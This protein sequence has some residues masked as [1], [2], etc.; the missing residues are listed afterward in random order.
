[1]GVG[2]RGLRDDGIELIFGGIDAGLRD[3]PKKLAGIRD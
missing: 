2:V 1:M 3:W